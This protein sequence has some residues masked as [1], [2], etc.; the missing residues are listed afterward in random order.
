M[1]IGEEFTVQE[2]CA[3]VRVG[4]SPRQEAGV[5]PAPVVRKV[6]PSRVYHGL[7]L[8][9]SGKVLYTVN[10]QTAFL[11]EP[12]MLLYL[13]QG[14]YYTVDTLESGECL[15]INFRLTGPSR[16]EAFLLT[17]RSP[18]RA[19]GLFEDVIA[20]RASR[21]P[22]SRAAGLSGLYALLALVEEQSSQAYLPGDRAALLKSANR[23]LQ[24]HLADAEFSVSDLPM[25]G[26]SY[27]HFRKLFRAY[28]GV[29]PHQ[30]LCDMRLQRARDL[31]LTTALPVSEIARQ[32]GYSS[33]YLFSRMFKAHSG[34]S[35]ALFR[36]SAQQ[37]N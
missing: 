23:T 30:Q 3:A 29:S 25:E 1:S 32:C 26:L 2:L 31:L 11:M 9:L 21:A 33:I 12:G 16:R 36:Q 4:V 20:S 19:R 24:E 14:V 15:A 8:Q 13:P 35:P 27:S 34:M 28:Y 22:G 18:I 37:D 17:L 5:Q 7:V 10:R 6:F